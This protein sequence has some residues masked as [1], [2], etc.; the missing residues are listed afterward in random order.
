M[1]CIWV[2]ETAL[3]MS[4]ENW[5]FL[6][7]AAFGPLPQRAWRSCFA[8]VVFDAGCTKSPSD[9]C[10]LVRVEGRNPCFYPTSV[11]TVWKR[12]G[13]LP[14]RGEICQPKRFTLQPFC[15]LNTVY[16]SLF[17]EKPAATV[18]W[19][20][21]LVIDRALGYLCICFVNLTPLASSA[22][23]ECFCDVCYCIYLFI[24]WHRLHQP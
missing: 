13:T 18:T 21:Q 2:T 14:P 8:P 17:Y 6:L 22:M 1:R 11:I 4:N 19:P 10:I 23:C 15:F 7:G 16:S 9:K 20:L 24:C 5:V 3:L 12:K